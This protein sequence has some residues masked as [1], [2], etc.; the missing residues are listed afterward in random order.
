ML[1]GMLAE[2][3]AELH[4]VWSASVDWSYVERVRPDVL[5]CEMAERFT[6]RVPS[7]DFD[8]AAH[9]GALIAERIVGPAQRN[10]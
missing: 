10:L 5:V 3:V 8:L 6:A 7:D 1:T 9:Q 2:T 4:F